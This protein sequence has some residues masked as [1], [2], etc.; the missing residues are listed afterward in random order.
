MREAQYLVAVS[1]AHRCVLPLADVIEVMRPLPVDA[2][3]QPRPFVRGL[4]MIRGVAVPVVDLLALLE[5][6]QTTRRFG[7]FVSLGLDG[8]EG[9]SGRR[10]ALGVEEVRGVIWLAEDRFVDLDPLLRDDDETD[11][12]ASVV[13][14]DAGLHRVLRAA[15]MVSSE[16]WSVMTIQGA[17]P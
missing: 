14:A 15:R 1:G 5:P 8:V 17:A 13:R 7:R 3:A 2:V 16:M 4:S 11:V 12:V 6:G 9:A 10:F